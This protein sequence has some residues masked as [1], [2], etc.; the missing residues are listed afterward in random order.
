M[1]R[2]RDRQGNILNPDPKLEIGFIEVCSQDGLLACAVYTDSN[3]F[4]HIVTHASDEA[5]RYS[6]IFG[7]EF[8]SI[9]KIP[10][11]LNN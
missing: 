6:Q 1:I 2:L 3:K 7:T 5:A 10:P 8:T 9:V 11:E 4:I